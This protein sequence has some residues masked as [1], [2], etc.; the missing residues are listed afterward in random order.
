MWESIVWLFQWL[1]L[2]K[3]NFVMRM[4]ETY[5]QLIV[6]FVLLIS[7][8]SSLFRSVVAVLLLAAVAAASDCRDGQV[9]LAGDTGGCSVSYVHA[10][11]RGNGTDLSLC[12]VLPGVREL[13]HLAAEWRPFASDVLRSFPA[14]EV[15]FLR[16]LL[17]LLLVL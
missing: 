15:C 10:V 14:L 17:L 2:F 12:P 8:F 5:N 7:S 1:F 16:F 11:C 4:F 3:E 13:M 6:C 9:V